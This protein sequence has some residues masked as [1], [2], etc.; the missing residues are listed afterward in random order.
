VSVDR[1][2]VCRLEKPMK[3]L[4]ILAF[5]EPLMEFAHVERGS[6]RLYLPGFGGDVSNVVVAA[7]RQGAKTA[8]FTALGD[9]PFG[10]DFMKLWDREGVERSSVLVRKGGRTGIYFISYGEHGH[11]FTYARTGSAAS[12][13]TEAELPLAQIAAARVLHVSG[14]SQAISESCADAGFAA[15]RAA[16][17]SGTTVSYDTNLR[18]RLWPLDRARAVIHAAVALSDIALPGLDDA[19]QLTGLDAPEQVCALYLGLGCKVVALTM[20]RA[21]TMVATPERREVIPARPVEAVD[22]TGAGDTFDGAFLAE[23]LSHGDPF[24]AASYANAAAA[25]ST[26][27]PGAVAPMPVR[28]SVEAFLRS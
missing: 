6:E 9:D 3:T 26:L 25:L 27:G 24:R 17:A 12:L 28:A 22:A 13:V 7:A 18:L 1:R 10:E 19:R 21:G 8:M 20:G 2:N 4:D 14:I 23:W 11:V 15:I 5:G 16:K